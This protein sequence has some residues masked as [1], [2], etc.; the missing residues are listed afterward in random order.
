MVNKE[1][2]VKAVIIILPYCVK[3]IK[4]MMLLRKWQWI[5]VS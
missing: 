5:Y 2:E 1:A 3:A 4:K